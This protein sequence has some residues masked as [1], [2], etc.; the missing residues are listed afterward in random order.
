MV[1]LTLL[2]RLSVPWLDCLFSFLEWLSVHGWIDSFRM[3]VCGMAGLTLLERL[4]VHGSID[5]LRMV[6]SAL[7]EWLSVVWQDCLF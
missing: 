5:S 2:V 6:V 4:S 7:L 1:A 3:V